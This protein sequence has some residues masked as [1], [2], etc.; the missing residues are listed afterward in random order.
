VASPRDQISWACAIEVT[1][2]EVGT[3]R[4]LLPGRG[5]AGACSIRWSV[6]SRSPAGCSGMLHGAGAPRRS[7]RRGRVQLITETETGIKGVSSVARLAGWVSAEGELC[8]LI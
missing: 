7:L 5:G 2:C 3:S 6:R 1:A 4:D 8:C